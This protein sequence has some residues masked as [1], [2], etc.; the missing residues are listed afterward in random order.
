M[1]TVQNWTGSIIS[2]PRVVVQADSV[3][4]IVAILKDRDKYPSPVRAVGSNHSTT[5]CGVA[6]QGTLIQ[7]KNMN[8]ILDVGPDTVT[9]EAGALYID[10]AH[11]LQKQNLQFYVNTEIGNLSIGS[12]A[13]GGTKD[14][15]MPGE[16]GQVSS[17][18]TNIKLVTPSGELM[19][20]TEDDP[21]LMQVARSSYGLLGVVYEV[22][23][24]TKAIKPMAVDHTEYSRE[25]FEREFPSLKE[26]DESMFMYIFPFLDSIV[27]E[28][29]KYRE[30]DGTTKPDESL[31]RLRNRVWST[32]Q[33]AAA[34]RITRLV[35]LKRL[36]YFLIDRSNARLKKVVN[37][38]LK[39]KH[40]LAPDQMI[41][42]PEIGGASKYT[43]SIWAFPEEVYFGV[44]REYFEFV[45]S[46]YKEK[47]YRCNLAN[48][49]YRIRKDT[50]SLFSYSFEGDV[51]TVDPVSTGDPGWN[52]FI[53]AYNEFC[54]ERKGVPLFN[55]SR[56]LTRAQV[57]KAF[58]DRIAIFRKY[59]ERFDPD[60]RLLN[61]YFKELLA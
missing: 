5:R 56:S 32:T 18:V 47:G 22:T 29:R 53:E 23:M 46:Y 20:I 13:C 52:E 60:D 41:R 33:P 11:E 28:F 35:P 45:K 40:T 12:A 7:M 37:L 44:L 17:Y 30:D 54:S 42:Y 9:A 50:S 61:T 21:E 19:E 48:V 49:G 3:D 34:A 27:V 25:E 8:R 10:V 6:D 24:R 59:R 15:S 4:N 26:R 31:W 55:Q 57:A 38:F 36:R 39:N 16:F 1:P 2:Q 51:M 14:A 58:G 43:F